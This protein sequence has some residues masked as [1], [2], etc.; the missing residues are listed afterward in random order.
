MMLSS[1]NILSLSRPFARWQCLAAARPRTRV[2]ERR[3]QPQR[4]EK[5][6][7]SCRLLGSDAQRARDTARVGAKE[8]LCEMRKHISNVPRDLRSGK[9][10]C[11]RSALG[12]CM[13]S[14]QSLARRAA[15]SSDRHGPP[16][17]RGAVVGRRMLRSGA[18]GI[19]NFRRVHELTEERARPRPA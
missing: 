17:P 2:I 8:K 4:G 12:I 15:R 14:I 1:H 5:K 6:K 16:R 19:L 3:A 7:L 11:G 13:V 18:P 10:G 9:V